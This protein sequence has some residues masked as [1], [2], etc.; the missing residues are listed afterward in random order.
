MTLAPV[1]W[2]YAAEV[3]SLGTRATG[4]GIAALGNWLFNF[5][6]NMFLPPAFVNIQWRI[7]IVFGVLCGRCVLVLPALSR[8]VWQDYR[9]DRDHVQQGGPPPL[10]DPEG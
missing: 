10:A 4:M 5:A 7:F 6:L 9:G 8:D 3:W 2:I 1:C